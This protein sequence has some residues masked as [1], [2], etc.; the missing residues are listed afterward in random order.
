MDIGI[1]IALVNKRLK[2]KSLLHYIRSKDFRLHYTLM[3]VRVLYFIGV[4][5]LQDRSP[6]ICYLTSLLIFKAFCSCFNVVL[7]IKY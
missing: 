2:E 6:S 3:Y 1:L 5:L 7:D 4:S